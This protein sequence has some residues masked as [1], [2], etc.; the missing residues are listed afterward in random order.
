MQEAAHD[1]MD[2]FD[3][4]LAFIHENRSAWTEDARAKAETGIYWQIVNSARVGLNSTRTARHAARSSWRN[5]QAG[6]TA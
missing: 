3:V 2:V 6:R 5:R 4:A 1:M